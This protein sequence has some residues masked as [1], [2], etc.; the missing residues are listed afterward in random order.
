MLGTALL[1]N[2]LIDLNGKSQLVECRVCNDWRV[3]L[4]DVE[5]RYSLCKS[6]WSV[7][8]ARKSPSRSTYSGNTNLAIGK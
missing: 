2:C 7:E 4:W 5:L 6:T 1:F 3:L 8:A